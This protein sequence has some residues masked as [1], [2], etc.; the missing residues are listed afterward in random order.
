METSTTARVEQSE[1][2]SRTLVSLLLLQSEAASDCLLFGPAGQMP[3]AL[4][5]VARAVAA[6][7]TKDVLMT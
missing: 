5:H 6:T 2:C 1:Q 7:A 4:E 3:I